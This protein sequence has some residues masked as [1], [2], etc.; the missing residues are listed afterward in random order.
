VAEKTWPM[1][2]K[3]AGEPISVVMSSA[4]SMARAWMPALSLASVSA[5]SS[6]VAFG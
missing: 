4:N 2:E 3:L 6:G 5:R 1:S